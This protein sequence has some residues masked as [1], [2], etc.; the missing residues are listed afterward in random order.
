MLGYEGQ[1]SA[2]LLELIGVRR[3]FLPSS[4]TRSARLLKSASIAM[5]V[6]AWRRSGFPVGEWGAAKPASEALKG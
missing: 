6:V 1:R 2:K 3:G 4:R 5:R